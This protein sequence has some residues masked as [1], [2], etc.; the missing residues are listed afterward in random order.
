MGQ[1]PASDRKV[2]KRRPVP[3]SQMMDDTMPAVAP[4]AANSS[5]GPAPSI[6]YHG[7]SIA[8]AASMGSLPLCVLLWGMASARRLSLM[9]PD[10]QGNNPMHFAAL[11][12]NPE[13]VGF[14][15]QQTKG[16]FADNVPLVECRNGSGE[17][18]LL[19]SMTV[20]TISVIKTLLE[21]ASDPFAIDHQGN[22][23]FT[24]LAKHGFL[25]S[26]HFLF[27]HISKQH[28]QS[29]AL[30]LLAC[31]DNEGHSAL[32]WAADAGNVNILEYLI[33]KGLN[34]LRVDSHKRSPLF[35]A[36]KARRL[37]AV[38]FLLRCGCDPLEKD[39][40]G[41]CCTRLARLLRSWDVLAE[42]NAHVRR[43]RSR[44]CCR[45]V[46]P[47]AED[48]LGQLAE[49]AH[50]REQYL[51]NER[52]CVLI[53][54][55]LVSSNSSV[56][57]GFADCMYS[58]P[59][60]SHAIYRAKPSRLGH[61]LT[62]WLL[63]LVYWLLAIVVPCYGWLPLVLVSLLV[64]RHFERKASQARKSVDGDRAQL[65][66][67][68][69]LLS[70]PE[71]GLGL[72]MGGMAAYLVL[73]FSAASAQ[74]GDG[75]QS[76]Q[77]LSEQSR[78]RLQNPLAIG[79][80]SMASSDPQLFWLCAA[81]ACICVA[82]WVWLV[83]LGPDPG[84]V[85]TRRADFDQVMSHSLAAQGPPPPHLFCR[86]SLVRK[87]LRSKYCA[88]LG[89]VVARFDHYCIWLNNSV[90]FKNHRAFVLFLLAHLLAS[91]LAIALI[92]RALYRETERG[93]ACEVLGSLLGRRLFF[94][95]V[96][97]CLMMLAAA[98]LGLLTAEQLTNILRNTTTNE[99]INGAKYSW[100]VLP[101]G[102]PCNRF[103]RGWVA[104]LL[105]FCG[106]AQYR[107]DYFTVFEAPQY[108]PAGSSSSSSSDVPPSVFSGAALPPLTVS[109]ATDGQLAPSRHNRAPS[110]SFPD[111]PV[112]AKQGVGPAASSSLMTPTSVQYLSNLQL[113]PQALSPQQSRDEEEGGEVYGPPQLLH[114]YRP[115][116]LDP[117]PQGP[118][119]GDRLRCEST[120]S[121]EATSITVGDRERDFL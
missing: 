119:Q 35:W 43:S 109:L 37:R 48:A 52:S 56:D 113:R 85:D 23:V 83:W 86:T 73:L 67:L 50:V 84:M 47:P 66:V 26:M 92:T 70:C 33:R 32:D 81:W 46:M 121:S 54:P 93:S 76:E 72:W 82:L 107:V 5:L 106:V 79:G 30:E 74:L 8:Q 45:F 102:S 4:T 17:T 55:P 49:V 10:G 112:L 9:A 69:E 71:K 105:E 41:Q 98:G 15:V 116:D 111:T 1:S 31:L 27:T 36:V 28:G 3:D 16:L 101:D 88:H 78:L 40:K 80:L 60:R 120:D 117:T 89:Y 29:A 110:A 34:P 38:R 62:Y 2:R 90:G 7:V 64:F 68:Q 104:N 21:A 20:G 91:S 57:S 65:T 99:R 87:P 94:V 114:S 6:S 100:M 13:V 118:L 97:D 58:G 19:R 61:A 77:R 63:V 24:L 22:S 59:S 25:W 51:A 108:R 75:Q 42:L 53:E 11:A 39:D 12:D 14:F 115:L 103:D 96:M 44:R 95:L 18:P